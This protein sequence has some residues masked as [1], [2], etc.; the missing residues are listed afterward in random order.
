[1]IINCGWGDPP[2]RRSGSVVP[3]DLDTARG[4]APRTPPLS[5]HARIRKV[6]STMWHR[7]YQTAGL[8]RRTIVWTRTCSIPRNGPA[9]WRS[10]YL[11]RPRAAAP[12]ANAW[13][14]RGLGGPTTVRKATRPWGPGAGKWDFP[15]SCPPGRVVGQDRRMENSRE[16][17]AW[18]SCFE[19]CQVRPRMVRQQ[20]GLPQRIEV[21]GGATERVARIV[22]PQRALAR[23]A[24]LLPGPLP[25]IDHE[26]LGE[27]RATATP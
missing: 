11:Y 2:A 3:L 6:A 17:L 12:K 21:S 24:R 1:M 22:E 4:N 25:G 23:H 9:A 15:V 26:L 27:G 5:Q 7:L 8:G 10:C 20:H 18:Q 19:A 16:R 14:R 13:S